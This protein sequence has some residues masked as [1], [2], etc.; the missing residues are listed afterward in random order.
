MQLGGML[1]RPS[2]PLVRGDGVPGRESMAHYQPPAALLCVYLVA[3]PVAWCLLEIA[4]GL[5]RCGGRCSSTRRGI[6]RRGRRSVI[7]SVGLLRKHARIHRRRPVWIAGWRG[8]LEVGFERP[9][10]IPRAR[11]RIAAAATTAGSTAVG[12]ATRS[13]WRA[14]VAPRGAVEACLEA[15]VPL[16]AIAE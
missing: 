4:H 7:E 15:D 1:L 11:H 5:V 9:V 13:A 12:T 16:Q 6:E 2:M 3:I 8:N 14:T 10:G